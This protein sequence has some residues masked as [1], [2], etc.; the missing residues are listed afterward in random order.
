VDE[1]AV[2]H[3]PAALGVYFALFVHHFQQLAAQLQ[4]LHPS[5]KGAGKE[6]IEEVLK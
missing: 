4:G 5:L 6:T 1:V 2:G 3:H